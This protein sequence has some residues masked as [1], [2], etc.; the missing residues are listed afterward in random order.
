MEKN[1][2]YNFVLLVSIILFTACGTDQKENP[3]E[4]DGPYSFFDASTPL[5]I[6]KSSTDA[7]GTVI[8]G[9]YN[10]TVRLLEFN[11]AKAGEFV[12][13]KPFSSA[14]GFVTETVVTTDESGTAKFIFNP[15]MGNDYNAIR[16]Q[17]ITIQ[18]IYLSSQEALATTESTDPTPPDILLT[19]D[20]VLQFR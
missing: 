7:N 14:Y 17:D 6:T 15:P 4:P 12:Q 3:S 1:I 16:G 2:M 19:Q 13:M 11:L 8:G 5:R 9:D 20:F 10:I 18:A